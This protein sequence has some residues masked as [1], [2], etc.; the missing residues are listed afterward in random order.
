MLVIALDLPVMVFGRSG[1][2]KFDSSSSISSCNEVF[3]SVQEGTT[4]V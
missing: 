3:E 2:M 4:A 1:F